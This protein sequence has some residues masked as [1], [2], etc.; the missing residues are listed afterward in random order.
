MSALVPA[1]G[2]RQTMAGLH[3]LF[4][5]ML[6]R[7]E[8]HAQIHFRHVRC[9]QQKDEVIAEAV[10]L[11]WKWVVRLTQRGKEVQSFVSVIAS[12]A[13]KAVKSGRR[14]CGQ[15]KA[16]D[17]LSPLAQQ[18]RGFTVG[19]LPD[20]SSLSS[21]PLM[22]ALADNTRTPP[23]EQAV[24]RIDFPVWLA[25][26]SERQRRIIEDLMEGERTLDVSQKYGISA[27]RI[28]QLR[29]QF[30]QDWQIFCGDLPCHTQ[31]S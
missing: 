27:G 2:P 10:A 1:G 26:F 14:L 7:I 9:P 5:L 4:L 22:E 25:T 8:Q 31:P 6:P 11:S 3:A 13:V 28:S 29:R 18:R 21:N 17:V 12:F 19:K 24:F 16:K 23:D 20:F 30:H 15:E